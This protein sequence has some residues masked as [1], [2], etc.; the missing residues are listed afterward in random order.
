MGSYLP[1]GYKNFETQRVDY[2]KGDM[3]YLFTDGYRDQFGGPNDKRM[4]MKPMIRLLESLHGLSL[5]EQKEALDTHFDLWKGD[6]GQVD[7]MLVM[8]VRL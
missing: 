4:G 5:R 1:S 2:A 6:R 8:G 3:L 7:D